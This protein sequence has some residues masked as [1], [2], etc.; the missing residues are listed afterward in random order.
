MKLDNYI[1]IPCT[2][3]REI[4]ETII[5]HLPESFQT[6][7]LFC[8]VDPSLFEINLYLKAY[9]EHIK[10]WHEVL[11]IVII[12]ATPGSTMPIHYDC[13]LI[14]LIE[15]GKGSRYALNI[16]L[17]NCD[18]I[19]TNFYKPLPHAVPV[20]KTGEYVTTDNEMLIYKPEDV[21]QIDSF[22]LSTPHLFNALVPHNAHNNTEQTRIIISLRFKTLFPNEPQHVL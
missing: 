12:S 13:D 21:E 5:P 11:S 1:P 15:S 14:P 20:K 6:H 10:P 19:V 2:I 16:P 22:V 7:N 18:S 8:P 17:Q 4:Q 9:V 3:L